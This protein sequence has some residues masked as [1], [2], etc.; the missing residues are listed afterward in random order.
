MLVKVSQKLPF[1]FTIM[2]CFV[3]IVSHAV[4]QNES[5]ILHTLS[6]CYFG[7]SATRPGLKLSST[8]V[9]KS[10]GSKRVKKNILIAPGIGAYYHHRNHTGVFINSELTYQVTYKNGF[11]WNVSVGAGYLRTF[12]AGRVYEVSADGEVSRLHFAGNNQFMPTAGIGF[13]KNL[14]KTASVTSIFF[15]F[16]GF[17]QYPFN[18]KWLP[19]ITLEFGTTIRLKSKK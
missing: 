9:E 2:V 17:L 19:N 3:L 1:K 11:M 12:L 10:M 15:R 13:G 16:G 6:I 5:P 18:S 4:A 8:L 7:K 14:V